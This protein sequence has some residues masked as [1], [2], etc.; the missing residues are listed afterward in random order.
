LPLFDQIGYTKFIISLSTPYQN[1]FQKTW[2]R[3][4]YQ[5]LPLLIIFSKYGTGIGRLMIA[6]GIKLSIETA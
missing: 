5:Q 2:H 4:V 3:E 1:H 6:Y